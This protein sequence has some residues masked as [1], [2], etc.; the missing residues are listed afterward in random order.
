MTETIIQ[1]SA[2][3]KFDILPELQGRWSPRVFQNREIRDEHLRSIFEAA[4]WAPSSMN[5]QPW[6][7]IYTKK[8][9]EAYQKI[10]DTLSDFNQKWAGNASVL[11]LTAYKKKF[12]TGKENFHALHDLGAA[13][14]SMAIQAQSLGIGVHQMAGVN[15][16]KAEKVFNIPEAYHVSSVTAL[17][18]YGGDIDDLNNDL[19]KQEEQSRQRKVQEEIVSM[20]VFPK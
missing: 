1:K 18:Y 7:F 20:N 14:M 9:S 11:I 2:S 16:E 6:R 4:R 8:G 15:H 19:Q 10:F 17:G 13:N 3:T 12:D 5:E